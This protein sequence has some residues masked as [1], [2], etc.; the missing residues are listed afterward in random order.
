MSS[1]PH[2]LSAEFVSLLTRH[3][4]DL[5]SYIITLMPG[6]PDTAD[7][8]QK[9][10]LVLWTKQRDFEPGSNFRAWA[11]A[12]ARFEVLAHLKRN[13]REGIVLLDEELLERIAHEAPDAL[14]PSELRLAAL[15]RCLNKLRPQDR[16]LLDHRYRTALG[17]EEFAARV[18]RSVS[19]LSVTLHRLRGSLRKCV[20]DQFLAEEGAS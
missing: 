20:Q 2:D 16:E 10:N 14:A 1:Q 11:F 4:P 13:K 9:T 6:D 12:V 18:G 5:W 19:A 17:L 8:L 3:Q 7:V 15:E